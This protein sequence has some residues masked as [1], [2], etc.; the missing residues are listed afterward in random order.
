MHAR[1]R[2]MERGRHPRSPSGRALP[3]CTPCLPTG[4]RRRPTSCYLAAPV[5]R[6]GMDL[7]YGPEYE[8]FRGEVRRFLEASWPLSGG[9][10]S[11]PKA[12]QVK[13]FRARAVEAGYLL[14]WIPKAYGGSEQPSDALRATII[15]E[16]FARARAP[17]EPRGIGMMMLVPTLLE[18]GAEWQKREFVPRTAMDEI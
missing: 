10:A 6:A 8:A 7:S 1:G 11:L 2:A 5:S 13:R 14:R 9:D 4:Q 3:S 17:H 12:E 18:K 16:E 15:R